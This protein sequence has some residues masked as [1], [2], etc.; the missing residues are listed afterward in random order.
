MT[1]LVSTRRKRRTTRD[2][3]CW[4]MR[5]RAAMLDGTF[6]IR[7]QAGVG[8]R[9]R[10]EIPIKEKK[11]MGKT[12]GSW[13]ADDHTLCVRA[14]R[15][16]LEVEPE[17]RIVGQARNG[18]EAVE[19]ALELTPDVILM[20]IAMPRLNGIEATRQVKKQLPAAKV[21]ILSMHSHAHYISELFEAG[22]SG[23]LVKDSTGTDIVDA[24]HAAVRGETYLSPSISKKLVD[25]YLSLKS[26]TEKRIC[27]TR[28]PP[29]AGSVSDD[30]GRYVHQGD[31][32]HPVHQPEHGKK[33]TASISWT[34]CRSTACPSCFSS[35]PNWAWRTWTPY[36][37]STGGTVFPR[38]F[39]CGLRPAW[40]DAAE[41]GRPLFVSPG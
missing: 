29:G 33:H 36:R 17:F 22:I 19:M 14:S 25:D 3:A 39:P 20:D 12:F 16:L 10:V 7:T 4:S 28:F 5:E 9:I 35:P 31:S 34:S 27:T 2:S 1:A 32:R 30:R 15:K 18:R 11:L 41:P 8:T 37:T 21:V 23:Y 6:S 38:T 24:I 13:L 26:G 40:R